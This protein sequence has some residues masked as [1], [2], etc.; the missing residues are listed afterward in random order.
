MLQ[1]IGGLTAAKRLK[2]PDVFALDLNCAIYHCAR[3]CPPYVPEERFQW[4]G[5]LIQEVLGYIQSMT[6]KVAPTQTVYI[7]VDGV[8]PMAKIKQQRARRFKSAVLAEQEARVKAEARGEVFEPV[9]RWDSNAITPGTEFMKRLATALRALT[10]SVRTI[11]S[12][13]DE[14][15][16]GEQKIMDWVRAQPDIESRD[17]V[18]YGLDADLIVLS[19]LE[20]ARSGRTVDL[21]REETEFNGAV[22]SNSL[23]DEQYLYLHT[24]LLASALHQQ[25]GSY[26]DLKSFLYSYVG[27]MNLLG[28]DF[29]PHGMA[30]KI[31]DEGIESVLEI[32]KNQQSLL[33]DSTHLKYD[34]SVML[35][36]MRELAAKESYKLL[37]GI[38]RK[39]GSRVG[40]S[41]VNATDPEVRAM[42]QL[43]DT[44]VEWAAEKCL[45]E[46][47]HVEGADKPSWQLRTDWREEYQRAALW[48]SEVS[49]VCE[50]YCKT[51]A[52]T[53]DY[54]VGRP[55]DKSWYYPWFLPPLFQSLVEFL[56]KQ[57]EHDAPVG[58]SQPLTPLAQLAMV[59]PATSMHLLPAV[60]QQLPQRY[61][62]AW[63]AAWSYFSLGRRFLW[64][65]EPLIPLI[66][67]HQIC[68]WMEECMEDD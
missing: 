32:L 6:R 5:R 8:A 44:P 10:L 7:A 2:A 64:E 56:E 66:Q 54:Y 30:L 60:L 19:L 36:V 9:A 16:E 21:F 23:G 34:W 27:A 58:K 41:G 55:V 17:I 45:V 42:A 47:R 3:K 14:A 18:V 22:K 28:N 31:N 40:S 63:P 52:W 33:V 38:R 67:P 53:L 50:S 62:H 37:R 4:E 13:A 35:S 61:P 29:V 11:V 49:Q 24:G 26:T 20:H 57:S 39:L 46:L 59:L 25:W 51:L 65:C 12:P 48:G 1:T 15:G 68:N 43:N